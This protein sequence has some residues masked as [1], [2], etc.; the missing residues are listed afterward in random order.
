MRDEC[1]LDTAIAEAVTEH[2]SGT[3]ESRSAE[4][5]ERPGH[6]AHELRDDLNTAPRQ[7]F[8]TLE[9]TLDVSVHTSTHAAHG[10]GRVLISFGNQRDDSLGREQ[11]G[12]N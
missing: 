2:G 1:V 3:T 11:K 4:E 8:A 9:S 7:L 10:R 5:I 12:G 6:A